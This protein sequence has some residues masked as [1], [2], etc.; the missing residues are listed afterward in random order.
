MDKIFSVKA[1][2]VFVAQDEWE[3]DDGEL[4]LVPGWYGGAF[5]TNNTGVWNGNMIEINDGEYTSTWRVTETT[6][7]PGVY[8]GDA[9]FSANN[10]SNYLT[11]ME[12][13]ITHDL[14]MYIADI[15]FLDEDGN[16]ISVPGFDS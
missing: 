7:R 13:G 6:I 9:V 3:S 8:G 4:S 16:V 10:E 14:D 15:T 2:L 1:D 5:G 11:L 12:W